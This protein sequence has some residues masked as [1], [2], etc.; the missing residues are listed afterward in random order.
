MQG[1]FYIFYILH[2]NQTTVVAKL[3]QECGCV[4]PQALDC[5]V[6]RSLCCVL[7]EQQRQTKLSHVNSAEI[8]TER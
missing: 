1:V 5:G 6:V 4:N 2:F 3:K 8:N 7:N